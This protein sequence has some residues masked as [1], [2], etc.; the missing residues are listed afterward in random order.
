MLKLNYNGHQHSD[1]RYP[2]EKD[3]DGT[4]PCDAVS[5]AEYK[6]MQ[7][8]DKRKYYRDWN[9]LT[10]AYYFGV[11]SSIVN[12]E[13]FSSLVHDIEKHCNDGSSVTATP[14]TA[15]LVGYLIRKHTNVAMAAYLSAVPTIIEGFVN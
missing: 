9:S 14:P 3:A 1:L 4:Y 7:S 5:Y 10:V 15:E 6:D 12:M 11:N 13:D 8:K 2:F